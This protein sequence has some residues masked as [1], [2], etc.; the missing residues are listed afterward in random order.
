MTHD[1][2]NLAELAE[3]FHRLGSSGFNEAHSQ[4]LGV[5]PQEARLIAA[6]LRRPTPSPD[7]A[8]LREALMRCGRAAGAFLA[9]DV[10]T[11]F[12]LLVPSEVEIRLASQDAPSAPPSDEVERIVAWLRSP[13][14]T[15]P[16][17]DWLTRR[18]LAERIERGD[19]R[20]PS[21]GEDHHGRE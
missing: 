10:S 5:T 13:T 4:V 2:T 15:I 9:D 18:N 7:V 19:W 16:G 11:E 21:Q 8:K 17:M 14:K 3:R 20:N 12:L 6:A 1:P